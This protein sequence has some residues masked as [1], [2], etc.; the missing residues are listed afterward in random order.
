MSFQDKRISVIDDGF[1]K[2][3]IFRLN[4]L[5]KLSNGIYFARMDADDI[6]LHNR[7]E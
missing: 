4:Q 7:I 3:L 6:M 1:N 5:I 2:G